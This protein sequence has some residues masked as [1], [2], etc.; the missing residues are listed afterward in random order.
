MERIT[1]VEGTAPVLLIA[2]HGVDDIATDY[3]A[4]CVAEEFGAFAVINK[5]WKRAHEVDYWRDFANCNDIRHIHTDVVKE[6]FL[7]PILRYVA[8]IKKKYQEK[9]FV[10]ILH[11]C[12]DAVR[13][14]VEDPFL[15]MI[16]GFG[17]GN[18]PSYTCNTRLKNAFIHH[19]KQENFG[20]Y[21]GKAKGNYSGR[22]KNNLNQL[23]RQWYPDKEVNSLQLEI[24]RELRSEKELI[25]VTIDGLMGAIDSLMLFDDTTNILQGETKKI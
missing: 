18:P 11:G 25:H 22:S 15:D 8:K 12:S 4:E 10:L 19:L 6:E 23:F 7:D 5:G 21:E 24:V 1:L 14:F 16:I 13:D 17:D 9:V 2:P 20:V 3:I